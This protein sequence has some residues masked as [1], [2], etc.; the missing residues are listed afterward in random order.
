MAVE[1]P[2]FDATGQLVMLVLVFGCSRYTLVLVPP[3]FASHDVKKMHKFI[4][5]TARFKKQP[6]VTDSSN[7]RTQ[8]RKAG[9]IEAGTEAGLNV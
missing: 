9:E 6:Q 7:R 3:M 4:A 5:A 2:V 1:T 8:S